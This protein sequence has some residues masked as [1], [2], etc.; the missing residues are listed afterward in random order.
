MSVESIQ[1]TLQSSE[2][3]KIRAKREAQTVRQTEESQQASQVQQLQQEQ[4]LQEQRAAETDTYDKENP[5]GVQAE[6]VYS[7]SHDESGNLKVNYVQPA[8]SDDTEEA[9]SA[10]PAKAESSQ[11]V[12]GAGGG[13][14]AV[15]SASSDDDTEL[16][17]LEQQR[18]AIRQQLNRETDENVKAQLRV[19]LQSIETEI[20]LK[21]SG[22]E[23]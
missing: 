4:R 16:E 12:S 10:Q 11:G 6:G 9:G 2:Q 17:E 1:G 21:S 18:D 15:S 5:V 7:L 22:V 8:K 19:Q 23:A 14:Q 13:T 3:Y 20:A